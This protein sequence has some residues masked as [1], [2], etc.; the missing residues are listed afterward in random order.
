MD[1]EFLE[2]LGL[3]EAAVTAILE[4]HGQAMASANLQH[5]VAMAI[6]AAGGR[7]QKAIT[8]LLDLEA[9]AKAEDLKAAAAEAV[10]AV[11]AE[12]GYLFESRQPPRYAINTGKAD[13]AAGN[14]PTTLAGAL[15]Q[16]MRR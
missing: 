1:R 2:G 16:R 13:P 5:Q 12:N 14:E 6:G 10:A 8:A 9:L 7:N 11:K 3:E 4:A 15:R